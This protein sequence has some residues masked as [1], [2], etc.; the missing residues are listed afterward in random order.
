MSCRS[1]VNLASRRSRRSWVFERSELAA[2]AFA[3]TLLASVET[4]GRQTTDSEKS[5]HPGWISPLR[6]LGVCDVEQRETLGVG[7]DR[8]LS[9][10]N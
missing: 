6:A 1:G 2:S 9:K 8:I 5:C 7:S 10:A 4:A 3:L